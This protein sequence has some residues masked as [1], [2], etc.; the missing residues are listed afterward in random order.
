MERN[1][2][3]LKLH[4]K[5]NELFTIVVVYGEIVSEGKLKSIILLASLST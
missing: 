4:K 3:K 2:E 5:N 1:K